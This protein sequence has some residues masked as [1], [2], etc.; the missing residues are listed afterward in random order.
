MHNSVFTE[1]GGSD[2]MVDWFAFDGESRFSIS[3]HD[4]PI[5]VYS[6][7]IAHITLF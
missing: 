2:K 4:T 1:S 5:G 3:E 6:K 7:E